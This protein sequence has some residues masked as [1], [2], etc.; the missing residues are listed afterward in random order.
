MNRRNKRTSSSQ[1]KYFLDTM[2]ANPRLAANTMSRAN[3]TKKWKEMGVE[4]NKCQLGPKLSAEEWRKRLNDWKNSTRSK[5][6]RCVV[7]GDRGSM[8]ALENRC[9]RIFFVGDT[10][11]RE[12]AAYDEFS[13]YDEEEQEEEFLD[14][15]HHAQYQEPEA[16]EGHPAVVLINGVDQSSAQRIRL[17]N[18]QSVIYE[19][20][21]LL[22]NTTSEK[23]EP[24]TS[25]AKEIQVQINRLS[26]IQEASL[27]FKIARF[28]YKNP[29]FEYNLHI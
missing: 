16:S 17:Q 18:P 15:E 4:L 12:P 20:E 13:D 9:M 7:T 14:D 23:E 3:Y 11:S 21:H 10:T 8:S 26:K 22:P 25:F 19:V 24:V 5:Y 6:R 1:Y 2:E 28:K 29:G 27:D